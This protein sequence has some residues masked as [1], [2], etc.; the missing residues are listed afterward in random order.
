MTN[1]TRKSH[2]EEFKLAAVKLV[3]EG[4]QTVPQAAKDL[5]IAKSMLYKWVAQYG[6]TDSINNKNNKLLEENKRLRHELGELKKK[7]AVTE[8]HR[9]ILKKAM[10]YFAAQT[11]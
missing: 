1:K 7:L 2:P 3:Q 8:E 9:E 10:A 4:K 11:L 5:G 6:E